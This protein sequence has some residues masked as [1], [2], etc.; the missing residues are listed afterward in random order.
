M[1]ASVASA[2]ARMLRTIS[3]SESIALFLW[4]ENLQIGQRM[5]VVTDEPTFGGDVSRL[6]LVNSGGVARD[7]KID[8]SAG[9]ETRKRR[10]TV[11]HFM[12][13]SSCG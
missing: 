4:L 8:I 7:I 6:A 12:M 10:F 3:I 13:V 2:M 11:Q 5:A 9:D 1:R